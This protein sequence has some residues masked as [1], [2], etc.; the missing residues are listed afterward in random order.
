[1]RP[2]IA[3]LALAMT[4]AACTKPMDVVI[5]SDVAKWDQ[6]LAPAVK[7]LKTEEQQ[8]LQNYLMRVKMSEALKGAGMPV[9]TTVGAAIAAQLKW[10]AEQAVLLAAERAKSL[11]EKALKERLAKEEAEA[12][13][14]LGNA[15][16][17]VLVSKGQEPENPS[18]GRYSPRQTFTIGVTNKAEKIVAG[19]SGQLVFVDMFDKVV[20]S[21]SFDITEP[22]SPYMDVKWHGARDYNQFIAA[23]RAVWDLKEGAYTTRFEPKAIVYDDGTKLTAR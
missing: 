16:T 8:L 4:L 18:A 10:D 19:V 9:G 17:V 13:A 3:F 12:K 14:L 22:I 5:P 6:D 21:V 2:Q 7:K 1:M 20:G 23:H 11:E 15:V